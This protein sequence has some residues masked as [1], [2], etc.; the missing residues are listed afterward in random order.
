MIQYHMGWVDRDFQKTKAT[1]GKRLRPLLLILCTEALFPQWQ[2]ALPAAAAVEL[3][4]NFTLIHDDIEDKDEMR[5]G[6]PTLWRL[7][8]IPQAINTG[9][10]LYTLAYRVLMSLSPEEIPYQQI[11]KIIRVFNNTI[12]RI[13]EGQYLDI[14]FETRSTVSE[15][16]YLD[17]IEGKTAAL[18][19]LSCELGAIISGATSDIQGQLKRFG[20]ALGMAFQMQDD[21]LGLWGDPDRTGKPVGSDLVK[22]KK[23]LPIIHCTQH[24]TYFSQLM[25]HSIENID[26]DKA[27]Q[28]LGSTSS[29][30]YTQNKAQFYLDQAITSLNCVLPCEKQGN[31]R[32]LVT[33]MLKRKM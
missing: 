3:L 10:A 21:I 27:M 30:T 8:G 32:Q 25:A 14:D 20:W 29:Y 22:K 15:S 28:F 4:H 16:E 23:T 11:V 17:M 24:N 18:F 6:R 31:L 2:V 1:T 5:H 13:T 33:R 26:I 12:L 19:A 9:D 7:W